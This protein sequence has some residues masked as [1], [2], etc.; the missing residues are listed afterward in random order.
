MFSNVPFCPQPT[1]VL[2]LPLLPAWGVAGVRQHRGEAAP[3]C[4]EPHQPP[5]QPAA[6]QSD[7]LSR[8]EFVFTKKGLMVGGGVFT[9][10]WKAITVLAESVT[11]LDWKLFTV[12]EC[13]KLHGAVVY[14]NK[15]AFVL[16]PFFFAPCSRCF[17]LGLWVF[18]TIFLAYYAL[19]SDLFCNKLEFLWVCPGV[20]KL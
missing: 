9:F 6:G 11:Q 13:V 16:G 12:T 20:R 15:G 1:P 18:V 3:T 5:P 19:Y 2:L 10:H 7:P 8:W 4:V 17:C 14:G